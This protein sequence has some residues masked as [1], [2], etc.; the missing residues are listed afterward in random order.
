MF[1]FVFR[2]RPRW[3]RLQIMQGLDIFLFKVYDVF[4]HDVY[5]AVL[6][7]PYYFIWLYD[8]A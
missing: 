1:R 5:L 3:S 4:S 7:F 2:M 8:F 6:C